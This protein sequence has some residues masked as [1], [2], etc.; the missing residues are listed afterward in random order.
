MAETIP[1]ARREVIAGRL[2]EGRPVVAAD[3]AAEFGVS[4]DAVRRDLRALAAD[5]LCRRVYGGALPLSPAGAPLATRMGEGL[6]EKR[7]LARAAAL[8]I[9]PGELVFLDSGSTNLALV[10]ALAPDLGLTVATNS[11]P[12]AAALL[13]REDVAMIGV[14]EAV[15]RVV[16]GGVDAGAVAS[17]RDMNIDRC[18][19]GACAV[20]ADGIS[21]FALGDALFKRALLS[22]S[23]ESLVLSTTAKLGTRA[24]HRVA[25]LDRIG[26]VVVGH[27][28]S[29]GD[30]APLAARS[31]VIVAAPPA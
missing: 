26:A 16:G 30:L 15:D 8:T 25:G 10:E 14:G 31:S 9:R 11:V 5:G 29:P 20:A 17:V 6:P 18:F 3:I 19:L 12:I 22:A 13:A 24:P 21:A 7:A 4:G 2:A 1:L 28:A 27:D 23:R